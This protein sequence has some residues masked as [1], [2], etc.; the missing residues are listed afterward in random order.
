MAMKV[1]TLGV[2][3]PVLGALSPGLLQNEAAVLLLKVHKLLISKG[4]GEK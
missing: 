1:Y 2:T 4:S 3:V